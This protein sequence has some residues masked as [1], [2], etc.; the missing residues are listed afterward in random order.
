LA[1]VVGALAMM[2]PAPGARAHG[3]TQRLEGVN[4]RALY[5]Q[6]CAI[7]H[8]VAGD[9]NGP[10]ARWLDQPA[11]DFTRGEYKFRSTP[12]GALPTDQDLHRVL[13]R[14]VPGTQM[15]GYAGRLSF[16]ERTALIEYIKGFSRRFSD[17]NELC[18]AQKACDPGFSCR[19]DGRCV[20]IVTPRPAPTR[21]TLAQGRALYAR[22]GCPE[23]HGPEGRGDGPSSNKLKD[24]Q[25]R[26]IPAYDFTNGD[27]KGGATPEDVYRTFSTGLSGTP[28]PSFADAIAPD[29]RW[30]LVEYVLSLSRPRGILDYLFLDQPGRYDVK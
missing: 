12:F 17:P 5:D 11:R 7:C 23:C 20:L 29:D 3:P 30:R 26:P 1:L 22:L 25:Q 28:M 15:P 8:G 16:R 18:S 10:G 14:G 21:S 4:A 27:Y 24:D 6:A 13:A 19:V 9:G 2:T